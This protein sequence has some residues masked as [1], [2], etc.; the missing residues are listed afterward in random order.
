MENIKNIRLSVLMTCHNRRETTLA[1][2]EALYLDIC[3][4]RKLTFRDKKL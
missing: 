1:C 4:Q 3:I 2:L